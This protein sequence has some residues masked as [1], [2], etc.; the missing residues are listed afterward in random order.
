MLPVKH[1]GAGLAPHLV[2]K[3]AGHNDI[4]TTML[5]AQDLDAM[6]HVTD[7]LPY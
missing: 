3:R 5:Y 7:D 2:Q 1:G 4:H 6:E